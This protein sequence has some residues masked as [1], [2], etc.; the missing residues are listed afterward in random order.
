MI[1]VV[2]EFRFYFFL[3]KMTEEASTE[4]RERDFS[5]DESFYYIV[6]T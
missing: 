5:V 6:F 2:T 3:V 1:K 4:A